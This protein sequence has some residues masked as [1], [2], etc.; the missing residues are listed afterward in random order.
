M[1]SAVICLDGD[2]QQPPDLIPQMI[3]K[4]KEGYDIVLAIREDPKEVPLF[5]RVTSKLYYKLF[6][7]LSKIEIPP[8]SCRFSIDGSESGRCS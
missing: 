3:D 8:R 6:N 2:L 5:K 4:W 1:G 7:T